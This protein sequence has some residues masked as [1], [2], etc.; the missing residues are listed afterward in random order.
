[1]KKVLK[2]IGYVVLSI[3][4][5]I[6]LAIGWFFYT[7]DGLDKPENEPFDEPIEI[8]L[9]ILDKNSQE[10]IIGAY[11]T[12]SCMQPRL[13]WD[14]PKQDIYDLKQHADGT[15][16]VALKRACEDYD[17]WITHPNYREVIRYTDF[18]QPRE[19]TEGINPLTIEMQPCKQPKTVY[20]ISSSHKQKLKKHTPFIGYQYGLW[21]H[22]KDTLNPILK[23]AEYGYNLDEFKITTN[24]EKMDMWL[25]DTD[26]VCKDSFSSSKEFIDKSSLFLEHYVCKRVKNKIIRLSEKADFVVKDKQGKQ[27]LVKSVPIE[28][29]CFKTVLVRIKNKNN[30]TYLQLNLDLQIA[31][32]FKQDILNLTDSKNKNLPVNKE[33]WKVY[34]GY[35]FRGYYQ[36]NGT[37]NFNFCGIL[38]FK[39]YFAEKN[40]VTG[41]NTVYK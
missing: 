41:S 5:I 21:T 15:Y 30:Y 20:R 4:A 38:D 19:I 29:A 27:K 36:S 7:F 6:L 26:K 22:H 40:N 12:F 23:V 16:R 39:E 18:S 17:V 9:H 34:V 31:Y 3:F 28:K 37:S 11:G 8:I 35:A 13:G 10:P 1:M 2:I 14:D 33:V 25:E 32:D 24:K